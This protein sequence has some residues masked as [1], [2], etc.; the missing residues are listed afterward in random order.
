MEETLECYLLERLPGQQRGDVDDPE[1][2]RIEEHLLWCEACQNRAEVMERQI[3]A[4]RTA[5]SAGSPGG[6][7]KRMAIGLPFG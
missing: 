3:A 2:R 4:L 5:L 1:V 6:K 7:L